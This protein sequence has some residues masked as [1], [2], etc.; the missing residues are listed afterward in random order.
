[1]KGPGPKLRYEF[2]RQVCPSQV[3]D[4][5]GPHEKPARCQRTT[6]SGVT[7]RRACFHPDQTHRAIT[8]TLLISRSAGVLANHREYILESPATMVKHFNELRDRPIRR[9]LTVNEEQLI[10][11]VAPPIFAWS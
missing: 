9:M 3:R 11:E 7:T 10:L 1:V 5:S 8:Q 4:A 6:V 2:S